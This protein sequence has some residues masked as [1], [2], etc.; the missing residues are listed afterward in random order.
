MKTIKK[1]FLLIFTIVFTGLLTVDSTAQNT[2]AGKTGLGVM[3]GEPTGIT[4]KSWTSQNTAF[5]VGLAWSLSGND[6]IY[7]HADHQWHK[8]LEVEKGNLAFFYGIGARAIFSNDT[9]F[10]ARIPLGLS[11]LAPEAPLEFYL[12][13][14]PVINLIPD[15]DG[16]ADGGIGIRY[17]F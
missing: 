11:Y 12:E 13:V 5:D 9:F 3:I 2:N 8:P 7:V 10:G 4:L 6:D 17:Y 16:D 15:T 14:A 1:S